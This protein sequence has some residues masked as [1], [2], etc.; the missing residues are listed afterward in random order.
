MLVVDR[1]LQAALM[2]IAD[3]F[4]LTQ[5]IHQILIDSG[6]SDKRKYRVSDLRKFLEY[7]RILGY[8]TTTVTN[9]T[10]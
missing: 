2:K 1:A 3:D 7:A 10:S 4:R 9:R 8:K 6:R 5:S